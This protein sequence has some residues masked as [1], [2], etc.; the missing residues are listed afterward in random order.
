MSAQ[1]KTGNEAD[2]IWQ[3]LVTLVMDSRGDWRRQVIELTGLP[4]SRVRALRRL[5]DAPLTLVDLAYAMSTDAPAA[6]V[7]VN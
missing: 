7:A 1:R 3:Q 2:R 4:F 6:T 5:V